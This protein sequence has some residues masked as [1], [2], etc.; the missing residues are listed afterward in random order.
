M[1]FLLT[2]GEATGKDKS[3]KKINWCSTLLDLASK[4]EDSGHV[5]LDSAFSSKVRIPT[6]AIDCGVIRP[7]SRHDK[8]CMKATFKPKC[9]NKRFLLIDSDSRQTNKYVLLIALE[10]NGDT[11]TF[12]SHMAGWP[13][14]GEGSVALC[15]GAAGTIDISKGKTVI[16]FK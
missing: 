10:K 16:H 15:G 3:T 9:R 13:T 7:Q 1:L 8:T 14:P 2:S 11:I 4:I 5:C 6:L 12:D